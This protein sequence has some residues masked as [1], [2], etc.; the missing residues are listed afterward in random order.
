MLRCHV[1]PAPQTGKIAITGMQETAEQPWLR[2][3]RPSADE[4]EG[5][6]RTVLSTSLK[7]ISLG[8]SVPQRA[9][10]TNKM[11]ALFPPVL[12]GVQPPCGELGG[13]LRCH[14]AAGFILG[15]HTQ[16]ALREW[17]AEIET[18]A[19][20]KR[21]VAAE[22]PDCNQAESFAVGIEDGTIGFCNTANYAALNTSLSADLRESQ[23]DELVELQ[24]C[25]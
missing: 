12:S 18:R 7:V 8:P 10:A 15:N 14:L 21:L 6:A 22:W 13:A 24:T 20:E 25:S 9:R 19:R 17:M 3:H 23:Q 11:T 5:S 4:I 16:V 1:Y 2:I